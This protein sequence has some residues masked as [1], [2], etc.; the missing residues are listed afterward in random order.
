MK[1]II[2]L[3]VLLAGLSSCGANDSNVKRPDESV[4]ADY[5]DVLIEEDI[6]PEKYFPGLIEKQ[7]SEWVI[8]GRKAKINYEYVPASIPLILES[9][10]MNVDNVHLFMKLIKIYYPNDHIVISVPENEYSLLSSY[11]SNAADN[12]NRTEIITNH[13][14]TD[15][16]EFLI[17]RD[18]R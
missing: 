12:S 8:I 13:S 5:S 2:I 9:S 18:I 1:N 6:V 10:D 7:S 3:I 17:K 16:A 14:A 4:L 11:I 15:A